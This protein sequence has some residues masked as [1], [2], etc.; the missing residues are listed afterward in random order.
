MLQVQ[1]PSTDRAGEHSTCATDN[2]ECSSSGTETG[3]DHQ[4][5]PERAESVGVGEARPPGFAKY[6]ATSVSESELVSTAIV[7]VCWWSSASGRVGGGSA[8]DQSTRL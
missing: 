7:K 4:E 6:S 1:V 5:D 2:V 8:R 3:V